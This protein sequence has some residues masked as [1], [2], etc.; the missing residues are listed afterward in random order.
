MGFLGT[1]ITISVVIPT[2][3]R[4]KYLERALKSVL[5]QNYKFL[6][7]IVVVD[8]F[9]ELTENL[10][11]N[12]NKSISNKIKIIH[13]MEKVGGSVARNIGVDNSKG[14][15]IALLDDDDEWYEDKITEQLNLLNKENLSSK[16]YFLCFTSVYTYK[17]VK[18]YKKLPRVNYNENLNETIVDYLFKPKGMLS[19]GFI[20]TSSVLV[21]KNILVETPFTPGLKKH[22][23]WD[24]LIK[25]DKNYNLKII[26][27][28]EPKVVYHT[29]IPKNNRVGSKNNWQFSEKWLYSHSDSFSRDSFENFVLFKIILGINSDNKLTSKEKKREIKIRMKKIS[30][31]TRIKLRFLLFNY[32]KLKK[33]Y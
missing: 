26:Q 20:Q 8:G 25:I 3:N 14:I 7:I 16:D 4:P 27:V 11:S 2:F 15:L 31:K 5:N 13:T 24:W 19:G 32:Y 17:D 33:I 12:M 23:D 22:Q 18:K 28:K 1:T 9:C 6:E 30:I 21:P 10:I 29:D